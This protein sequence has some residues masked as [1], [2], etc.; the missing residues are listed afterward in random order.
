VEDQAVGEQLVV[1]ADLALLSAV[2][3]GDEA[4]ATEGEPLHEVVERLALVGR[5][6]DRGAQVGIPE[7]LQQEARADGAAQLAEG[8][9]SALHSGYFVAPRSCTSSTMR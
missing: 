6:L 7:V 2:V 4:A 3:L 1:R 9:S 5:G 8:R